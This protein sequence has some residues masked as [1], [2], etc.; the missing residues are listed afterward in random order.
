MSIPEHV[1][2][3]G[4]PAWARRLSLDRVVC[5]DTCPRMCACKFH[6]LRQWLTQQ[7]PQEPATSQAA[8]LR[9]QIETITHAVDELRNCM[10]HVDMLMDELL[11]TGAHMPVLVIQRTMD[12]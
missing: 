12:E 9:T 4:T 10:F 1:W 11:G 2:V 8:S 6:A 3:S 5:P 7:R